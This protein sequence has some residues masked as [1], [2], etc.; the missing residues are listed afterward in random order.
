MKHKKEIILTAAVV[1]IVTY[2]VMDIWRKR[3][4][5]LWRL[6]AGESTYERHHKLKTPNAKK[7][8]IK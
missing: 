2:A 8:Q 4:V 6:A 1:S 7:H 3:R 5:R